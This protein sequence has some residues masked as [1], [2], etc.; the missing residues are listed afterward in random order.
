MN[1][2]TGSASPLTLIEGTELH[3]FES[4]DT[5]D[6][7]PGAAVQTPDQLCLTSASPIME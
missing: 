4:A 6:R 2:N 3:V 1:V 7:L 5:G